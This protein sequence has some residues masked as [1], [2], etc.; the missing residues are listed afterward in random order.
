ML[1]IVRLSSHVNDIILSPFSYGEV[2]KAI[3]I[4]HAANQNI[5]KNYNETNTPGNKQQSGQLNKLMEPE[6]RIIIRIVT[7]ESKTSAGDIARW[8]IHSEIV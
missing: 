4:S 3:E 6:N 2:L 7:I 5:I 8:H 1:K